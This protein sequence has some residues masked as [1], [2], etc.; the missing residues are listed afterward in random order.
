[1]TEIKPCPFC[2]HPVDLDDRDTLYPDGVGWQYRKNGLKSY[3]HFSEVPPEQ[4]CYV[5]CCVEKAGGC[6]AE[7]HGDTAQECIDKW[8]RRV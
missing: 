8:N 5:L 6:G 7:M 2:G 3:H 1:M 4:W